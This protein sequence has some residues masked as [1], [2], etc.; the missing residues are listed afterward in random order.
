MNGKQTQERRFMWVCCVAAIVLCC[1]CAGR[2]LL[3]A[4]VLPVCSCALVCSAVCV[5][6]LC[7]ALC[8]ILLCYVCG[9]RMNSCAV[10]FFSIMFGSRCG[11]VHAIAIVL[12]CT[13]LCYVC[14]FFQ[15]AQLCCVSCWSA[16]LSGVIAVRCSAL[17][18]CALLCSA[19]E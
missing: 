12:W 18:C 1:R 5:A 16:A 2:A 9:V 19:L 3:C 6:L 13:M 11:C 4:A 14:V 10:W 17:L 15:C 8:C 7:G